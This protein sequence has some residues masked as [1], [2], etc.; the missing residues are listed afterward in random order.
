MKTKTIIF[1]SAFRLFVPDLPPFCEEED[2]TNSDEKLA[3]CLKFI[4][5]QFMLVNQEMFPRFIFQ[6][7]H[8][9]VFLWMISEEYSAIWIQLN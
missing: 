9:L 1:F 7:I 8:L 4:I 3:T 6:K 2:G 5:N